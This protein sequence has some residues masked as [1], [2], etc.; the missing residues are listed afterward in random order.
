MGFSIY[1]SMDLFSRNTP[2]SSFALRMYEDDVG[3]V[4]LGESELFHYRYIINTPDFKV[5]AFN[6]RVFKMEAYL[7]NTNELLSTYTYGKCDKNNYGQ[8]VLNYV[9][10]EGF[11]VGACIDSQF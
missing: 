1:F 3:E 7:F 11:E 8:I 5:K 4:Q 9:I 6:S 10:K 2:R